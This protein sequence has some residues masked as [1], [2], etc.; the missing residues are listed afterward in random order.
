MSRN[1]GWPTVTPFGPTYGNLQIQS[2]DFYRAAEENGWTVLSGAGSLPS[3]ASSAS[4]FSTAPGGARMVVF[5]LRSSTSTAVATIR[6]DGGTAT[7]GGNG[8]DYGMGGPYA[9][10]LNAAELANVNGIQ[11][12]GTVTG[13]FEYW[14]IP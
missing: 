3:M 4:L 1:N 10:P 8:I 5:C 13:W 12:G 11:S 14:G 7:A 6:S 2:M 9:L